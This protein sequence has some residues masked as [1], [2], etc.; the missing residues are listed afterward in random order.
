VADRAAWVLDAWMREHPF[1]DD[2]RAQ[3]F[4]Y[5]AGIGLFRRRPWALGVAAART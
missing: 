5:A 3:V 1:S 2:P 4:T